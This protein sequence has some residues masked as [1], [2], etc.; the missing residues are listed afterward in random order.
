M[1]IAAVL[2]LL[3]IILMPFFTRVIFIIAR[4]IKGEDSLD[5]TINPLK[6]KLYRKLIYIFIPTYFLLILI[7]LL[8]ILSVFLSDTNIP[9]KAIMYAGVFIFIIFCVE[10]TLIFF[11]FRYM[12]KI[13]PRPKLGSDNKTILEW[14]NKNFDLMR[15]NL[16]RFFL[17]FIGCILFLLIIFGIIIYFLG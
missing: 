15:K 11:H 12:N 3:F 13:N 17:M 2:L 6:I 5:K 16:G 9:T 4:L 8:W 1:K 7:S 14:E 10:G